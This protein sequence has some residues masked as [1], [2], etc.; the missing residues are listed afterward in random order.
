MDTKVDAKHLPALLG[1]AGKAIASQPGAS[2]VVA[3][4]RLATSAKDLAYALQNVD[5]G[6]EEPARKIIWE[7][8][9]DE[10]RWRETHALLLRSAEQ[11]LIDKFSSSS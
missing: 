1:S 5:L 4:I 9:M 2:R 11:H 10:D 7:A 3:R 8:A 6:V